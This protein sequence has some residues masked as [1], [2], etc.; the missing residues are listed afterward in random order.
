M[1]AIREVTL[2]I[3]LSYIAAGSDWQHE[4]QNALAQSKAMLAVVSP[5]YLQSEFA[6]REY[7]TF[8]LSGRPIFP[9]VLEEF[10]PNKDEV[11]AL[12]GDLQY[13]AA[14]NIRSRKRNEQYYEFI[15]H[16]ARRIA[17]TLHGAE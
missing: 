17:D 15:E 3:D 13:D 16:L 6:R 7:E 1:A 12:L 8:V 4:L 2:W 9:L 11:R 14:P 10:H 5:G